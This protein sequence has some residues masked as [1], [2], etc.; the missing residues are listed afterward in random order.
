[1]PTRLSLDALAAL[2]AIDSR[3][4]FAAAAKALHRVPSALSYTVNKLEDDLGVRLF[5]RSARKAVLTPAGRE[6]LEEGRQLLALAGDLEFRVRHVARG[7][8]VELRIAVDNLVPAETLLEL[9]PEFDRLKTGTRLRFFYEVLGGTWD[10]LVSGRCELAIGA[11]GEPPSLSGF[12]VREMSRLKFLFCVAPGH[13]LAKLPEPLKPAQIFAHRAVAVGDSSRTG[14]PRS[15][16]LMTGQ[17]TLVVPDIAAKV[18]AQ[19]RGLG[20]GYLPESLAREEADAG[21]LLIR[22]V[23]EPKHEATQYVAWRTSNKGKALAWWIEHLN[24]KTCS[25]ALARQRVT[26]VDAG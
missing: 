2:D 14:V 12:S 9:V 22:R 4:S 11:G 10:A 16:G 19:R 3:G 18:V 26:R 23:A 8:E 6:L 25:R 17:E 21:R 7:W 24:E 13:P 5:D 1:M 15:S 20:V